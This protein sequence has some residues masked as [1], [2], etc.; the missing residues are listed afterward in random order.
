VKRVQLIKA[1]SQVQGFNTPRLELEQYD[2]P[3]DAAASF[4][5]EAQRRG[6]IEGLRIADLGC[7]TG[8][9]LVG[10]ALLGAESVEGVEVDEIPLA[11]AHQAA[12]EAGVQERCRFTNSEVSHWQGQ[13]DTVVMN[14]PFGSQRKRADRPFIERALNTAQHVHSLHLAVNSNYWESTLARRNLTVEKVQRFNIKLPYT[15]P[16]HTRSSNIIEMVHLYIE[17]RGK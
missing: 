1:L 13:V 6:H 11:Q 8:R 17:A 7:G 3:P 12:I 16:H 15:Y 10:A 4:L 2:T 9:L 14:P 5:L